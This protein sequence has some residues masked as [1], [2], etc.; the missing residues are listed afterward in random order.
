M[1][2]NDLLS[3]NQNYVVGIS[4]GPDSVFLLHWL[5]KLG[6]KNLIPVHVNYNKRKSS[7]DDEEVF[8]NM[9]QVNGLNYWVKKVSKKDY[10]NYDYKNFQSLARIIRYDFFASIANQQNAKILI[11]HNLNDSIE[12]YIIQKER[13]AL[14]SHWGL[15][16]KTQYGKNKIEV[17]R[18]M[19]D[20][21]KKDI[22]D[23]LNKN[24][25]KYAID[26]TNFE[27]IYRRNII[28]KKLK[29]D[30][31]EFYIKS[32][33]SDNNILENQAIL[34]KKY[35]N[36]VII[37]NVVNIKKL[38]NLK[39]ELIQKIIFNYFKNN[40]L[41]NLVLNRSHSLIKEIV[42]Q[43]KSPKP[44]IQINLKNNW[45]FV[46]AYDKA[47]IIQNFLKYNFKTI[48]INDI[49]K[50]NWSSFG[51][52]FVKMQKIS[53]STTQKNKLPKD[54]Y[55]FFINQA[56]MPLTIT[57]DPK[58]ISKVK[59]GSLKLNKFYIKKKIPKIDRSKFI[60]LNS[61]NELLIISNFKTISRNQDEDK[62]ILLIFN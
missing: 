49:I 42:K 21:I 27:N 8:K 52:N 50:F 59:I 11:A 61:K 6:Y 62:N 37:D 56:D 25:I 46:K 54:G 19:L 13:K 18:P 51:L 34:V 2:N 31:F 36:I 41:Q 47:F 26:P 28:R 7:G 45:S 17:I 48:V 16:A 40:D 24:N 43:V 30:S 60:I 35:Y 10:D 23:Y 4:G 44:N 5:I 14:V 58:V 53:S 1:L 57:N 9:C 15:S 39:S 29:S 22:V 3:K 12:T 38:I 32:I 20:L 55:Y 33:I